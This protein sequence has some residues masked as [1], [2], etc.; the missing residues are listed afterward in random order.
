MRVLAFVLAAAAAVVA[1]DLNITSITGRDGHSGDTP[2][3]LRYPLLE[4]I[5]VPS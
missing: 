4:D 1:Q 3:K 2:L 5:L